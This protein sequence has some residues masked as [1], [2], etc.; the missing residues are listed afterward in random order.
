MRAKLW[1]VTG[2][3]AELQKDRRTITAALRGVP[4][5][6][7]D[8]RWDAWHMTTAL[9]ALGGGKNGEGII[10]FNVERARLTQ[11]QAEKVLRENAEANGE[12][13]R[14]TE[15]HQMM[16]ASFTRVRSKLL[17]LPSG[18]APYLAEAKT[19]GETHEILKSAIHRVLGEL[20]ATRAADCF[21]T[22]DDPEVA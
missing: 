14:V 10:D 1:T 9:E 5:D 3:A 19:P 20:A 15:Y 8:G 21:D 17:G 11:A 18:L 12:L 2:L 22:D 4:A 7:K 13:I 16:T 6:G